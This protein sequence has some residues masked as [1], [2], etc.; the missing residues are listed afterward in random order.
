MMLFFIKCI[1]FKFNLV[2]VSVIN[3]RLI[4]T[5]HLSLNH[6][7]LC[8]VMRFCHAVQIATCAI[9]V[10]RLFVRDIRQV[11]STSHDFTACSSFGEGIRA[12]WCEG[13]LK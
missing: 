5:S 9:F 10:V 8:S 2:R 1:N 6:T 7:R 11:E 4:S 3:Y 13:R 12:E